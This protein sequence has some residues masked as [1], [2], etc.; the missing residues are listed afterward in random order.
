MNWFKIAIVFLPLLVLFS[1][2][3]FFS[4]I[5]PQANFTPTASQNDIINQFENALH[6]SSLQPTGLKYFGFRHEIIFNIKNTTVIFSSNL[7]PIIQVTALQNLLKTSNIKGRGL[8]FIDLS[9]SHP[10]ATFE[11]N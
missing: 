2:I 10:Y 5:H 8:K 4:S 9:S 1:E 11:N 7:S 3:I 6:L